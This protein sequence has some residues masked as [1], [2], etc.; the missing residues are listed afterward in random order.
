MIHD[1]AENCH[2]IHQTD[3]L[4]VVFSKAFDKVGHTRLMTKLTFYRITKHSHT[5]VDLT[6]PIW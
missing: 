5:H 2:K 1:I 4:V 3:V 6:L